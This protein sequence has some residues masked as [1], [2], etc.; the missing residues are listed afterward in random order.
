LILIDPLAVI[1]CLMLTKSSAEE[2]CSV[3]FSAFGERV[4]KKRI[5]GCFNIILEI[6]SER[7]TY[8][9]TCSQLSRVVDKCFVAIKQAF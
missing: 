9:N 2:P 7:V 6:I 8:C 3:L 5:K 1:S 4:Y